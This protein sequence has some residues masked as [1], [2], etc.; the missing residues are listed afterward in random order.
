ME[1]QRVLP[2]EVAYQQVEESA[3]PGLALD[4]SEAGTLVA[5]EQTLTQLLALV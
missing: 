1:G 5:Q 3:V 2:P 4:Q